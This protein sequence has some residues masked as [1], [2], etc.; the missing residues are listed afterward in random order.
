MIN[1]TGTFAHVQ[2]H[3]YINASPTSNLIRLPRWVVSSDL[4]ILHRG[5]PASLIYH[6]IISA[7]LVDKSSSYVSIV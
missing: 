4:D 2:S 7:E 6:P 3:M 1:Y 5:S